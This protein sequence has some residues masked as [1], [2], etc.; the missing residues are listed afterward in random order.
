MSQ[1]TTTALRSTFTLAPL[2]YAYDAL[3]PR[4]SEETLRFHHD[5]HAAGYVAK[6]NELI[7]DTPYEGMSLEDII[8]ESDGPIFNNAAQAWNHDFYFAALSPEPQP[9]PE[10]ALL[11][12]VNARF[13]SFGELGKDFEA[14]ALALFG[15]GYVWLAADDRGELQIRSTPNAQNPLR[16]GLTPLLC[17]DVWEHAYYID[18]RNVR[19]EAVKQFWKCVDWSTVGRRYAEVC[20][21]EQQ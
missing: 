5:K 8:R 17:I 1:P 2:P 21:H 18:Y 16:E 7:A 13:G 4:I 10:G 20:R 12:A 3:A 19:A 15:S 14:A 6:L 9:G 11:E